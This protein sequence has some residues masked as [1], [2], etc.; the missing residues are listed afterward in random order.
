MSPI[1]YLGQLAL[2]AGAWW[3]RRVLMA[4]K[5]FQKKVAVDKSDHELAVL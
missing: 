3:R 5:H 1:L 2:G 4:E